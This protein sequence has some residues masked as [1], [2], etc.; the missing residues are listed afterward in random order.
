MP[1]TRSQGEPLTSYDLELN[2]T[3]RRMNNQG[4]QVNPIGGNLGDEV[5]LQPPRVVGGENQVLAENQLGY[6][7]RVHGPPG[8]R[9]HDNYRGNARYGNSTENGLVQRSTDPI[10][11]P[12]IHPRTVDAVR[13]SQPWMQKSIAESEAKMERRMEGMM[14]RKIQAVNKHLDAFELR[15]LERPTPPI[16]LS[17]SQSELA[18]LRADVDAIIV[19]P[20]VEPQAAPTTLADDTVLDSVGPPRR[21]LSLHIPKVPPV[22]RDVVSTIDG[23]VGVTESTTEGSMIVDV[24]TTEGD[25]SM[26][27]AGS[28]KLDPPTC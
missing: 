9:P 5:E 10:D 22:V 13:R 4:V 18:S 15:V 17:S 20:T 12:S 8:P 16:D 21:G 25:P 14:D 6:V 3:L 2:R 1:S 11:G 24:G 7:M 19:T 27:P 28:E 23:D 26:V